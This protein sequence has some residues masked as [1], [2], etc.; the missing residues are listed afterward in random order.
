MA[1]AKMGCTVSPHDFS[2][3]K[4]YLC[5]DI[6]GQLAETMFR[7]QKNTFPFL[8]TCQPGSWQLQPNVAQILCTFYCITTDQPHTKCNPKFL[9]EP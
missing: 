7:P 6:I 1:T 8:Y 3:V 4:Q 9:S 5:T 2:T